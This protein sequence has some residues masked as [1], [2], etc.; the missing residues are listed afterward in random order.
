M[1]E[2]AGI[3]FLGAPN[4]LESTHGRLFADA[5]APRNPQEI[6]GEW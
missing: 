1:S 4:A 6:G 2:I 3:P 5:G